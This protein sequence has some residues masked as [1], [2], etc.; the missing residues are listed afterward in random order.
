MQG[1]DYYKTGM[2]IDSNTI[3]EK[4]KSSYGNLKQKEVKDL[5][6]ENLVPAKDGLII[7]EK[8]KKY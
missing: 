8:A 1:Q 3:P 7:F 6:M 4:A 5:N 2:H